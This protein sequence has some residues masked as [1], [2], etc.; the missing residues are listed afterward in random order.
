M[1]QNWNTV[2]E[3]VAEANQKAVNA[4]TEFNRIA[5]RTQGLLVRK[6]IAA[7]ETCLDAGA[8]HMKVAAETQDPK[9]AIK[10][11]ADVAVELGEKL[12][13]ATQESFEI[14]VQARDELARWIEDGIKA[15][16]DETETKSAPVAARKRSVRKAA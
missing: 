13:A 7:L 1:Q 16:Q 3:T 15:V 10:L 11:H 2:L 12:V 9:E 4:A 5:T 8:K 6:Q 14:Q